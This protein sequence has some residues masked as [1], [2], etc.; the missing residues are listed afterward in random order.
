M[1][2]NN[3]YYFLENKNII[4][5]FEYVLF[6][7]IIKIQKAENLFLYH[8]EELD[9][10]FYNNLKNNKLWLNFNTK[11]Y[12]IKIENNNFYKKLFYDMNIYGGIYLMKLMFITK[13]I[14]NYLF[15][16]YIKYD[17]KLYGIASQSNINN[18]D[19]FKNLNVFNLNEK[20]FYKLDNSDI[21]SKIVYDY[22][23]SSYFNIIYNYYFLDL[24]IE[25]DE[26]IYENLINSKITIFNLLLYYLLGYY[27]YFNVENRTEKNNNDYI[28]HIDKIY[29]INLDESNSRND[30]IKL[31]LD[32]TNI[33][34]E[35]HAGLNGKI[36][37][38]IKNSYFQSKEL[39]NDNSNCEYAVLYSHLSLLNKLQDKKDNYFLIFEDD[40]CLDFKKYW[41]KSIEEIINGAPPD[42][43]IIMLGYFTLDHKFESEYRVWN[44]DWSA[45]SYIIKKSSL[46]K[47]NNY[48]KDD[49][50]Y[51]FDDV[52][53]AD[54]YLFRVFKTY[55]YKYPLFTIN[56][57]NKSTFH[58]DHD[59]YQKIYKNINL[60]ILNNLINIYF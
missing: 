3:Y 57:N 21:Y 28:N 41:N 18:F 25:Y 23:F 1:I 44:N 40:L 59:H 8:N 52:N 60:I 4:N 7:S 29:Y 20:L 31:I 17:N 49:K 26:L 14:Q 10:K 6:Y 19:D 47:L 35:R 54:N 38:N 27:Y 37:N 13:N 50:Y 12:F 16:K 45:L 53:V 51:L 2:E 55:L 46:N 34:Y 58:N 30:N 48:I 42:W 43:E 22:N 24:D 9:G 56:N 32:E 36:V 33:S 15:H 5:L 11:I 39:I